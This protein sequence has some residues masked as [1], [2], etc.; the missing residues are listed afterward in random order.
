[1]V[2]N[3]EEKGGTDLREQKQPIIRMNWGLGLLPRSL[4]APLRFDPEIPR[5]KDEIAK[6]PS[7]I[8]G[9]ASRESAEEPGA[10]NALSNENR[11]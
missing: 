5:R 11:C 10:E 4:D 8:R 3:P 2:E 7:G 6:E 9:E 1:M